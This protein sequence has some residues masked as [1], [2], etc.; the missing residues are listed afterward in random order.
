MKNSQETIRNYKAR[1]KKAMEAAGVDPDLHCHIS[2]GNKK[3]G[4]ILNVS[5]LPV[6]SCGNCK[7]C[8]GYCYAIRT[9]GYSVDALRAWAANT[10]MIQTMGKRSEYFDQIRN[11]IKRYRGKNKYFRWHV[12]G[13]IP[14]P[15]Y[16]RCMVEIAKEFP[17]WRFY[18]YT[19]RY[20]IVN[21]WKELPGNLVIMYSHWNGM[22]CPNPYNRPEFRTR[23]NG[24][25]E[26]QF[27]GLYK[28]PGNCRECISKFRGCPYG[29]TTYNDEH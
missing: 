20:D 10:V 23:L 18:G 8:M 24:M 29:E 14:D 17:D 15:G 7:A 4:K 13:D 21:H 26:K 19:K 28:C 27:E 12:S 9:T 5:L 22:E 25:D 2:N 16:F 11:R 1:A 6:F 3:I